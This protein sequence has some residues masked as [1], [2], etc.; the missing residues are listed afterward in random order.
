MLV[1]L[2]VFEHWS[3]Q[4]I[5]YISRQ[6]TAFLVVLKDSGLRF[7]AEA[8]AAV[9]ARL[10]VKNTQQVRKEGRAGFIE[11][12]VPLG[13]TNHANL[14]HETCERCADSDKYCPT[15]NFSSNR[16]AWALCSSLV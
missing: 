8:E 2:K 7:A 3:D 11:E 15:F 4:A 14:S 9:L 16:H 10:N 1:V 6:R 5:L 13:V 12:H